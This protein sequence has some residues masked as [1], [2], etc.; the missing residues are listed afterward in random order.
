MMDHHKRHLSLSQEEQQ[1]LA[2]IENRLSRS[3]PRF[4]ARIGGGRR[5]RLPG[6]VIPAMVLAIGASVMLLSFAAS[7]AIASV[8]AFVFAGGL[9]LAIRRWPP[10][11][12][13]ACG[14]H[15]PSGTTTTGG[16]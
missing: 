1:A 14:G 2:A 5:T 9:A 8:G 4:A 10:W 12:V 11:R 13:R 15:I 16:K 7:V 3:D 6:W